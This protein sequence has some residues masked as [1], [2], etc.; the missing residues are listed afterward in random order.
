MN[1]GEFNFDFMWRRQTNK[2]VKIT[3]ETGTVQKGSEVVIDIEYTPISEHQ[4]NNFKMVLSLVSGPRYEFSLTGKARKPGVKLNSNLF[5]FGPSFVTSQPG[6]ITKMLEITNQD[7]QAISIESNFEKKNYLDFQIVPGQVIM[8]DEKLEIP[9]IFTPREIKKYEE[10]IKLDFNGLYFVDMKIMGQGIPMH[11]DLKDPEHHKV[12][13]GT[14]SVD[15]KS[16]RTIPLINRSIKPV[17]F[18]IFPATSAF[19]KQDLSLKLPGN[20]LTDIVLKPKEQL[21]IEIKFRPT[22][23]MLNFAHDVMIR[24]EGL[25]ENRKLFTVSGVAQGIELRVMDDILAFGSVVK[26]SRLTKSI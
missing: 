6:P 14:I 18:S 17:K 19:E 7:A 26:D 11:L 5:D 4:L 16:N 10:S 24:I 20:K 12:D 13:M 9:I 3:P 2:Y 22:V 15:G 23:R 1:N 25:E 8:P 21:P